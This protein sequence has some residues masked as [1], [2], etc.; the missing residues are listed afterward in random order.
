MATGDLT[1]A[2]A[3]ERLH[4]AS[5]NLQRSLS[6]VARGVIAHGHLAE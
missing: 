2:A 1:T 3:Y 6:D 5:R 4:R